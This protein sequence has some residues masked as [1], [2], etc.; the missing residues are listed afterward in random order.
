MASSNSNKRR[1]RIQRIIQNFHL[2][3][4]DGNINENDDDFCNSIQKLKQVVNTVNTFVD[5][6]ECID[7]INEIPEE[8]AFM[9]TSGALG[10]TTVPAIHNKKQVSVIY[11]FCGNKDRHEKWAKEWPKVKGVFTDIKPICEALKQAAQDCDQNAVSISFAPTEDSTANKD[12]LDCSFM[13]TEILKEI[14]L[15]IHFD[16]EHINE[17]LNHCRIEFAENSFELRN[18]N[19]I[20]KEYR[21]HQPIWWYTCETFL[22]SMLNR[23]LRLMDVDI[24]IQMGFFVCDLHKNIADLHSK[25]FHGQT[26]SQSFIV[27]RGQSLAQPD[28]NQLKQNQGGLLAFNNFLSTSENRETSLEFIRRN[29][30]KNESVSILFVMCINPSIQSTPFAHVANISEISE[31]EEILFSMHSVFRIGKI[32]QFSDK[33]QIWE[34][35]LTLTDDNDS[36][37][38]ELSETI[39]KE[40]SGSTGWN[41]LGQLLIKLAKFDK[42]EALYEILLKQTTDQKEKANIFHQLGLT[43]KHRGEYSKALEYYEKSL[44]IDKKTLPANHPL[45]ATSYNNIGLVYQS[46]GEYSKALEYYEKSLEIRKKTL[47][48]NHPDL[49]QSYNNIGNVY[50]SMGEYSKALEYYE[51]SL[52]I[53]KKTLP[54]NHSDLAISYNNIGLV[55]KSMGEYSK[56]LQYY[57]K[58]LEIRKKSL[59]A[60]HPSLATSYNNIGSVYYSM[61]EYSKALEYYEKSLE[62]MKKTLPANHPSLATSYNNIGWVYRNKTD[63]KKALDYY[64]RALDIWQ[65][66]LPSNHPSIQNVKESID[67]VKKKLQL[68]LFFSTYKK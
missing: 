45:L 53:Y 16:D 58:S 55:Y 26:S 14:L 50:K 33:P 18:V 17:F 57:E 67:F 42:A 35:E 43:N 20:E 68:T 13:Y 25:Q 59:P 9:I 12:N 51:K 22:Y 34:A 11:I 48:A 30:S 63:Y 56:A 10:Q 2:V 21:D 54:A 8:T 31:E 23:A 27:Y 3:W 24:I 39:Q 1:S 29:P 6:D 40:T 5:F 38:R 62:I 49:A 52:E 61:G 65:R 64:E 47:P 4:L 36:Q 66:S 19:K 7:F 46:M 15:T 37:L 44:E 60:N 32:K 28:F 41:R